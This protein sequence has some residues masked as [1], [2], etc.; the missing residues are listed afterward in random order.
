MDG[1]LEGIPFAHSRPP[2]LAGS[3]GYSPT[4]LSCGY[5]EQQAAHGDTLKQPSGDLAGIAKTYTL[6]FIMEEARP[7]YY[8]TGFFLSMAVS[9]S[10]T[11]WWEGIYLVQNV[12]GRRDRSGPGECPGRWG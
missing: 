8:W 11:P 10:I 1:L 12:I 4:P 7:A 9:L 6:K 2:S 3:E 5:G